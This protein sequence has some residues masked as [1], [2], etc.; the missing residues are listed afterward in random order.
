MT[1]DIFVN[2]SLNIEKLGHKP[3][4]DELKSLNTIDKWQTVANGATG[5]IIEKFITAGNSICGAVKDGGISDSNI[6]KVSLLFIDIDTLDKIENVLSLDVVKNHAL[7]V[8]HTFSSTESNPR[9]R[10]VYLLDDYIDKKLAKATLVKLHRIFGTD[11]DVDKSCIDPGRLYYGSSKGVIFR[12]Y[13]NRLPSDYGL[14]QFDSGVVKEYET[15]DTTVSSEKL[16]GIWK[17]IREDLADIFSDIGMF[18][19]IYF[20]DISDIKEITPQRSNVERQFRG[21]PTYR[22][23]TSGLSFD[24]FFNDDGSVTWCDKSNPQE[25]KGHF[26]DY[27]YRFSNGDIKKGIPFEDHKAFYNTLKMIYDQASVEFIKGKFIAEKVKNEIPHLDLFIIKHTQKGVRIKPNQIKIAE[28]FLSEHPYH[29]YCLADKCVYFWNDEIAI[30][31]KYESKQVSKLLIDWL[32]SL[33]GDEHLAVYYEYF[34]ESILNACQSLIVKMIEKVESDLPKQSENIIPFA[35]GFFNIQTRE[36]EQPNAKFLNLY[37]L[38]YNYTPDDTGYLDIFRD[39]LSELLA[40]KDQLSDVIKWLTIAV[41]LRGSHANTV[42]GFYGDSGSGKTAVTEAILD[43]I[44]PGRDITMSA[45]FT[46]ILGDRSNYGSS[47][48]IG[49]KLVCFSEFSS[50]HELSQN[51]LSR[52]KDLTAAKSFTVDYNVKYGAKGSSKE[53]FGIMM[54]SQD[55]P[56]IDIA[57]I[58]LYRRLFWIGFKKSTKDLSSQFELLTDEHFLSNLYSDFLKLPYLEYI[59]YFQNGSFT[60]S[61]NFKKIAHEISKKSDPFIEAFEELIEVTNDPKDR[62]KLSNLNQRFSEYFTIENIYVRR[63][64]SRRFNKLFQRAY[65]MICPTSKIDY[66]TNNKYYKGIKFR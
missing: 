37:R 46:T 22:D 32:K 39:L 33:F 55:I 64:D 65:Q 54:T 53:A 48:L 19:A 10:V 20:P 16:T 13:E 17:I 45:N 44:S 25:I 5:L 63:Y 47:Q 56:E 11:I 52:F 57:D 18:L 62:I 21:N 66:N 4:Q 40:D 27:Y 42:A 49:K 61:E 50:F 26:I 29:F 14:D 41:N 1:L 12:N 58:G 31:E 30:Y 3:N 36:F 34:S 6:T 15:D 23:S 59:E 60:E 43:L 28:V 38:P 7:L 51:E 35:N 9:L 24:I 8:H 2:S